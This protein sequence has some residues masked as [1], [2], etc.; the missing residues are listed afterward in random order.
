M[1]FVT[2]DIA[3]EV[4]GLRARGVLFEE[5]TTPAITTMDSIADVGSLKAAWFK[6]IEGNL[7]RSWTRWSRS[8]RKPPFRAYRGGDMV[9]RLELN[10]QVVRNHFEA[11]N[12]ANYDLLTRSTILK[13]ATMSEQPSIHRNGRRK[14]S[15]SAL[16]TSRRHSNGYGAGSRISKWSSSILLRRGRS[17][18]FESQRAS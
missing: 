12:E 14:M 3:S 6:D 17:P 9:D 2:D 10:K 13:G 16:A 18:L 8:T 5:Y 15:R 4:K 7:V 1:A 11:L